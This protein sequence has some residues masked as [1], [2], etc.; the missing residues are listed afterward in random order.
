MKVTRPMRRP[1][2]T[3]RER[4]SDE[5]HEGQAREGYDL[6]QEPSILRSFGGA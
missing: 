1:A 4:R 6:P 5:E 2:T 3:P